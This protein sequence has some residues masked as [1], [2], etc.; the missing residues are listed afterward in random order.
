MP[1]ESGRVCA[2]SFKDGESIPADLVVM[3]VGIRPNTELAKSAGLYCNRGVVVNDTMQTYDPRIYAVGECVQHR[4]TGLRAGGAAVRAGQGL[5]QSSRRIRHRPLHRLGHL[6]QAQGHR[7][8]SVF[9]RRFHR[10]RQHRIHRAV[11]PGRRRST[12]KWCSRTT[13]DRRRDVRRHHGRHLVFP[14]AARRHRRLRLPRQACCSARRTWAIP[15]TASSSPR[16]RH[17][18]Q[19][20]DLRLQRRVQG[21]HRQGHPRQETVHAGR[22]AR[23]HQGLQLLRFLHR[24][25]RVASGRAPSAATTP[26]RRSRNRCARAPSTPT[27]RCARRSPARRSRPCRR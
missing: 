8:R 9:G 19:R 4:G 11:R 22:G 2:V 12:R 27:T 21:R 15:V 7:H 23:P 24:P 14:A 6:D 13:A 25:G 10:R 17:A 5:R 3:A 18:G 20:R 16:R 26:P 1:G